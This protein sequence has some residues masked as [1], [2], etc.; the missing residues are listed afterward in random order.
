MENLRLFIKLTR[1]LFLVGVALLY[2]LGAGIAKYLGVRIDWGFYILGQ[3]WV[4]L[5]QLSTQ[6]LNEYFNAPMDQN[7]PNRT[8]LTGGS[9]AVGPQLGTTGVARRKVVYGDDDS[10][11]DTPA[12]SRS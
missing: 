12:H 11:L 9:G 4:T 2:A 6:Y 3:L 7:N 8:F 5:L 1:P 10:Q